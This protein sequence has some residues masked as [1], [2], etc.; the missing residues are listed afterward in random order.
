MSALVHVPK[1]TVNKDDLASGDKDKIWLS[2]KVFRGKTTAPSLIV[3][4]KIR[5]S[6]PIQNR[7]HNFSRATLLAG[8]FSPAG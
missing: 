4:S 8:G 1:T 2:W 5:F 7:C 3:I 6:S